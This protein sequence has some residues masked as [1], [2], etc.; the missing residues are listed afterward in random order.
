MPTYLHPFTHRHKTDILCYM[1][2]W[3]YIFLSVHQLM[4]QYICLWINFQTICL[5]VYLS[6]LC[7]SIC[8]SIHLSLCQSVSTFIFSAVCL[9]I[10]VHFVIWLPVWLSVCLSFCLSIYLFV[11]VCV[12]LYSPIFLSIHFFNIIYLFLACIPPSF[13]HNDLQIQV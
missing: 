7:L 11:W 12:T 2:I 6:L 9:A 13:L 8:F 5:S 10:C 3:I 1:Q 4:Y